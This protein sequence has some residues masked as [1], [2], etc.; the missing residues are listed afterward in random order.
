VATDLD[1]RVRYRPSRVQPPPDECPLTECLTLLAG[2]WTPN[3]IWYLR[4]G[5]RRFNELRGDLRGVSG[6]TLSTRLKKLEADGVV[7]R[8][9]RPTSPPTVEYAL[10][11]LGIELIP[12]VDTIVEIGHRLKQQRRD[13]AWLVDGTSTAP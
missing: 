4:E 12:A 7:S 3:V 13:A 10:T 8:T 1:D 9:V 5:P 6:K 11:D 2:T